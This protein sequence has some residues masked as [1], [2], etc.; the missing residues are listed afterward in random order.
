MQAN[1]SRLFRLNLGHALKSR[2]GSFHHCG[3]VHRTRGPSNIHTNTGKAGQEARGRFLFP[4]AKHQVRTV[5]YSSSSGLQIGERIS[6]QFRNNNCRISRENQ[7]PS[8]NRKQSEPT[9]WP[10]T[11]ELRNQRSNPRQPWTATPNRAQ[12]SFRILPRNLTAH[13]P[14][15][16]QPPGAD[17]DYPL[18]GS[19]ELANRGPLIRA[20]RL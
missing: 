18:L 19:L 7:L 11:A 5:S 8:L 20:A 2:Q 12:R 14:V 9:G 17:L 6:E 13:A 3:S 4:N 15:R 16:F 10:I 1:E